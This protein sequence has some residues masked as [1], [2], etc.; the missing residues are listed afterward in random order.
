MTPTLTKVAVAL[1][2]SR[3]AWNSCWCHRHHRAT[4]TL[5][6]SLWTENHGIST[7]FSV[8]FHWISMAKVNGFFHGFLTWKTHEKP[9]N[10]PWIFP[11]SWPMKTLEVKWRQWNTHGYTMKFYWALMM[12]FHGFFMLMKSPWLQNLML[13]LDFRTHEKPMVFALIWK[14]SWVM[15]ISARV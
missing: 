1:F 13:A 7:D 4:A 9:L 3:I 8:V 6:P 14:Y 15:K 11:V 12:P 10:I 2:W 5:P